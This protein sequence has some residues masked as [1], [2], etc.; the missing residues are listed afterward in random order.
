MLADYIKAGG[1]VLLLSGD[2][3]F[4]QAD[5]KNENF[6]KVL[7]LTFSGC[8]DYARLK[9]PSP[10]LVKEKHPVLNGVELPACDLVL[11]SHTLNPIKGAIIP[12]VFADG[13]PALIISGDKG[14]N[15][16]ALAPL[17]FGNVPTEKK[18][19][20][21]GEQYHLL[22]ANLMKLLMGTMEK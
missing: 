15:V 6:L 14:R 7:P 3:T 1:G 19:Y 2:R 21:N 13:R 18:L 12:L 5:F 20:C 17:P 16:A 10:I 8:G 22:M 11:Y 9:A 4:G